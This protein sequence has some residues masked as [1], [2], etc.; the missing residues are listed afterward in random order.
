M[1]ND[2]ISRKDLIEILEPFL[3]EHCSEYIK[4]MVIAKIKCMP[5]AERNEDGA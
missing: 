3:D 1:N 5:A 4:K 2:L